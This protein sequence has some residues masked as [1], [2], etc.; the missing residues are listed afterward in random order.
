MPSLHDYAQFIDRLT[1]TGFMTLSLV[2]ADIPSLA[3]E[4][5][6]A[7]WHTGD[8]ETDPWGWKDRAAEEKRLAYGCILGGHKGFISPALYPLF[9]R[10][11]HPAHS[12]EERWHAGEVNQTTYQLWSLFERKAT[13]DTAEVRKSLGVTA[14]RGASRVDGALRDLQREFYLTVTGSRRKIGRDGLPYGWAASMFS[15]VTAWI[16]L[17]WR[18]PPAQLTIE[19]A[20]EQ[21]L[22]LAERNVPGADRSAIAR[23]LGW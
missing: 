19:A 18:T 11:C 3:A 16:P 23:V 21:I 20:R 15:P 14:S 22:D 1:A 10:A 17:D 2:R 4:T 9:Y 8:P 7:Q 6:P 5:S 13:L 12:L